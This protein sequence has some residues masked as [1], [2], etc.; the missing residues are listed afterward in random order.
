MEKFK[1]GSIIVGTLGIVAMLG[2]TT[3]CHD[4]SD[5]NHSEKQLLWKAE[6]GEL[7]ISDAGVSFK[8]PGNKDNWLIAKP[9]RLPENVLFTCVD[10]TSQACVMFMDFS[11]YG[12]VNSMTDEFLVSLIKKIMHQQDEV[13]KDSLY[14]TR[15]IFR[16]KSYMQF[17]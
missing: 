10:T 14:Y 3:A 4:K 9:E 5:S 6:S 17:H 1:I 11:E 2:S 16:D 13:K 7:I 12:S 8:L 15:G